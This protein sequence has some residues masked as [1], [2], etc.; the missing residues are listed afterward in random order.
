[1]YSYAAVL[2]H[3]GH[4]NGADQMIYYAGCLICMASTLVSV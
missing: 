1:M 4:R 2:I 3:Y